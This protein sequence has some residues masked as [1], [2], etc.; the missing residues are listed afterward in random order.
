MATFYGLNTNTSSGFFNSMLG[1]SSGSNNLYSSLSASLGDYAA[2]KNGSYRKL[3]KAYYAQQA[4]ETNKSGEN[5]KKSTVNSAYDVLAGNTN[6]FD[7]K[8]LVELSTKA[9]ALKTSSEAL[10]KRGSDSL[11]QK[12]EVKD[13]TGAIT[14][15]YDRDKIF[16]AVKSF[17]EDYNAL[18]TQTA[19][20]DNTS[21]LRK[22]VN[23]IQN[24]ASYE[25]SLSDIGITI[26]EDNTLSIDEEKFKKADMLDVKSMFNG[27]VSMTGKVYQKAADIYNLSA[28]AASSN[29]LYNNNAAYV[30]ALSGTLYNSY[31]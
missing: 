6:S 31:L 5:N 8:P 10:M 12:K 24:T 3:V 9:D 16:Q 23:M 14:S 21:I 4:E 30:N 1:S 19:K 18:V 15:Q 25:E 7:K 29:S 2:I 13:E 26:N 17:T 28:N 27:S 20:T 11:F 22:G